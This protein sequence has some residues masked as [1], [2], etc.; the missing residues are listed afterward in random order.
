MQLDRSNQEHWTQAIQ[1]QGRLLDLK[2]AEL[3]QHRDLVYLFVRRDFVVQYKQTILGPLWHFLQPLITTLVFTVVF[4]KIAGISTDG[5]PP[6]MFYMT[7]VIIWTYFSGVLVNASGTL[8]N[9]AGILRKIYFPRLVMPLASLLARLIAFGIQFIFLL[10][11][12]LYFLHQGADINP[13]RWLLATPL[14][15]LMVALLGTGV[16]LIISA[17]TVRYRDLN[18]LIGFGVQL[19][20]Y[21]TPIIYP[22][23]ALPDELYFWMMLNPMASIMEM[24]RYAI[25]G[26]GQVDLVMLAYSFV[27]IELTFLIG[28]VLFNH[29]ERTSIDTL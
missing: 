3:W 12:L 1:P 16:G 27:I 2:L 28:I 19:W 29:A 10:G 5:V 17:L 14:L 20:M 7:G 23:S 24:F 18:V 15:L 11:F 21:A 9:N 22:M 4:S 26:V 25:L 8:I 13:N 6:F